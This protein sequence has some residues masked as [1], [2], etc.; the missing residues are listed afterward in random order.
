MNIALQLFCL[1]CVLVI[2]QWVWKAAQSPHMSKK[3]HL[4]W[5]RVLSLPG[6]AWPKGKALKCSEE[7]LLFWLCLEKGNTI[8]S[9]SEQ[10]QTG[11]QS[12]N[13]KLTVNLL[14][15]H[16]QKG[17]GWCVLESLWQEQAWQDAAIEGTYRHLRGSKE[18]VGGRQ[19]KKPTKLEQQDCLL[20]I[21]RHRNSKPAFTNSEHR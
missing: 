12:Y 15:K 3:T 10:R 6:E 14:S 5:L 13:S 18:G 16:K 20:H 2:L 21:T 9:F 11:K 4:K 1:V 8:P 17:G 7:K 19:P